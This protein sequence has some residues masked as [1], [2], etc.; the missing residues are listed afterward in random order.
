MEGFSVIMPTYNQVTYIRRAIMSLLQQT[1]KG[2]EL[3]IINDGCTDDTEE[4]IQDFLSNQQIIYLKNSRNEGLGYTLNRGLEKA[5]YNYIAYLPSDD[6]YYNNHLAVLYDTLEKSPECILA[7][8]KARSEINDSM[9]AE[10][11]SAL[12]GVFNK[13]SLQ[14]VQVVHKK[15]TDR[16]ITRDE[17]VSDNYFDLFWHK[18]SDKGMFVYA[19]EETSGW[20]IHANQYHQLVNEDY[21][22]GLNIYRQYY[23][24]QDPIKL[25]VSKHKFIDEVELYKNYTTKES[26]VTSEPSLKIL[27][28]GELAYNPERIFAFEEQGHKL[29]GLWMR[30]PTYSFSTV[31]HLPFGNI[32]DIPYHDWEAKVKEI[33]PDIIYA[34][35]NYG[36][37]PLAYEVHQKMP[38]IPFVWHFKE[39]PSV[40][41]KN[42]TW[43]KLINLYTHADGKIY[44]NPELKLWY[45]QFIPQKGLSFI[46]DG[47][48]P[49]ADC[50]TDNFSPRLSQLDGEIHTVVPGRMVGIDISALKVLAENKIHV[51]L[52]TE[53][54]YKS[55]DD[56]NKEAQRNA[57]GYFHTHPHCA[58]DRWVE[59]FSQYDAGWLHCFNSQNKG[60][61][62]DTGWNDLNMPARMNTLAAAGL[63]MIQKDNSEHIVAMQSH[64]RKNN[65][66]IFFNT[67]EE[68]SMKLKD[69][70]LVD[71]L[72]E[73]VRNYRLSFTFD[74]YVKDLIDF[75]RKVIQYK[76]DNA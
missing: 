10:Y 12:N 40:C 3:I 62:M 73:N 68:L 5:K 1:F 50:F 19:N 48:M 58:A 11:R 15:T 69:D 56:L 20:T 14:L 28:V 38:G 17:W 74:Y 18:L 31:G 24:I 70:K 46:M 26:K 49:K 32:T 4:Y 47:D 51:H 7:F 53:N 23:N 9:V 66:G 75:F 65:L 39:S 25:K 60:K 41:R 43:E 64:I 35:L 37:V 42:G 72:R 55:R 63:P 67:Y 30:K 44:L 54:Y 61:I 27:I 29:F 21:G 59:E 8:S 76:K 22:G 13:H 71:T 6:F 45:E 16:W 52:Y 33:K 34:T 57:P 2:W 36:A